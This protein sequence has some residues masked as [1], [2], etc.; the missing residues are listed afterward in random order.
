MLFELASTPARTS[1]DNGRGLLF[2]ALV[3]KGTME[4]KYWLLQQL[5]TRENRE[6]LFLTYRH[7][8]VIGYHLCKQYPFNLYASTATSKHGSQKTN[9]ICNINSSQQHINRHDRSIIKILSSPLLSSPPHRTLYSILRTSTPPPNPQPPNPLIPS[10]TLYNKLY[11]IHGGSSKGMY[12]FFWNAHVCSRGG[13]RIFYGR[14]ELDLEK[15][16]RARGAGGALSAR[17]E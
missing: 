7:W 11:H 8:G 15:S 12:F 14:R 10:P 16:K 1:C 5:L 17:A 9:V 3:K 6:L 4:R 2:M 13:S